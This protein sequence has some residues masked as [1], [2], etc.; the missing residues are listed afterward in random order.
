MGDPAACLPGA[1]LQDLPAA[2]RS[3]A[4][5][6][7]RAWSSARRTHLPAI[8]RLF[9]KI[10][11]KNPQ[12]HCALTYQPQPCCLPCPSQALIA[13]SGGQLS[14]S[15]SVAVLPEVSIP[16]QAQGS[17][18]ATEGVW[19]GQDL[20]VRLVVAH[21]VAS[22]Q[23]LL[24]SPPLF[25][26]SAALDNFSYYES[27][28]RKVHV[29]ANCTQQQ[30]PG[31]PPT[32]TTTITTTH[33]LTRRCSA[34]NRPRAP[35]ATHH[36]QALAA[37]G[38]PYWAA[39]VLVPPAADRV[40]PFPAWSGGL[41]THGAVA[42]QC[43]LSEYY[44]V[45]EVWNGR[46]GRQGCWV[47]GGR[48]GGG[49]QADRQAG[50]QQKLRSPAS[51]PWP[52]AVLSPPHTHTHTHTHSWATCWVSTIPSSWPPRQAAAWQARRPPPSPHPLTPWA[53][54]PRSWRVRAPTPTPWTSWPAAR[55]TIGTHGLI[56]C[57]CLGGG[58]A[59]FK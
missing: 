6:S 55:A 56:M 25:R 20:P 12:V 11:T 10:S 33:T 36:A 59:W 1:C 50:R 13:A 19:V 7:Q 41:T 3:K 4:G 27:P 54:R 37:S 48:E 43:Y 38:L 44:A 51:Q 47:E 22:C 2:R 34:A 23:H 32:T 21:H 40:P 49:T 28:P 45:H 52:T 30:W 17:R 57:V 58:R 39:Y 16:R 24:C 35:R 29:G 8:F 5:R 46:A 15:A 42:T 31:P 14:L 26:L 9:R 18:A 53:L